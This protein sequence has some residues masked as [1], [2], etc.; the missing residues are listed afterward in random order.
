MTLI[1]QR[2]FKLSIPHPRHTEGR[3]QK[4]PFGAAI[5]AG[6]GMLGIYIV[7]DLLAI[8][9]GWLNHIG[10]V[11]GVAASLLIGARQFHVAGRKERLDAP[12]T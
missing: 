8:R 4:S 2:L 11:G 12:V 10:W 5:L 6:I 9:L 3:L 7:L 1:S